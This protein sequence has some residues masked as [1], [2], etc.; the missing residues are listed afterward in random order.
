[1][2][3]TTYYDFDFPPYL[4]NHGSFV[5]Y[6]GPFPCVPFRL[7]KDQEGNRIGFYGDNSGT[8]ILKDA[9]V[10]LC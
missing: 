7:T 4:G 10:R 2:D 6:K 5:W 1:M 3:D 8:I 9:G